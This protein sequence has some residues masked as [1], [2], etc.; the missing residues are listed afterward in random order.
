MSVSLLNDS[1]KVLFHRVHF[2]II[3]LTHSFYHALPKVLIRNI[4]N[5]SENSFRIS[6]GSNELVWATVWVVIDDTI[7][8]KWL[9]I[10]NSSKLWR[11]WHSNVFEALHSSYSFGIIYA[12]EQ[13]QSRSFFCQIS[14]RFIFWW[15][16]LFC[17]RINCSASYW[18]CV[19]WWCCFR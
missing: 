17:M 11:L 12:N 10:E 14:H 8:D 5:N 18:V 2:W 15:L 9:N 16:L 13:N 4:N 7:L 19:C 1:F 3:L 6:E